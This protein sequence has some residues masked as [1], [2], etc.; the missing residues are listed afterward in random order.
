MSTHRVSH[1]GI[2]TLS[3]Q[4]WV[5][6]NHTK[7]IQVF[8][9]GLTPKAVSMNL[10]IDFCRIS[11]SLSSTARSW[12]FA[13]YSTIY[14]TSILKASSLVLRLVCKNFSLYLCHYLSLYFLRHRQLL[15][16]FNSHTTNKSTSIHSIRGRY[17][18]PTAT[19][20][21]F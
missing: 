16:L 20:T 13:R 9:L 6:L 11:L 15:K 17:S 14:C 5:F 12:S 4:K 8:S 21:F 19:L 2:S 1:I 7:F 10:S 3:I 18:L